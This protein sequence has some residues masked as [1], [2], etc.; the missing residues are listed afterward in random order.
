N[1]ALR[2]KAAM[3]Y[4]F[5][6]RSIAIIG[7]SGVPSKPGGAPLRSLLNNGYTGAVFPVNPNYTT[8]AGLPC[9][10][11]LADIPEEIDL[12]IIAVAA[13]PAMEAL[14]ECAAKKVKAAIVFSSGFAETDSAGATIQEEMVELAKTSGIALC[15]PNCMGIFNAINKMTAGFVISRIPDNL[16]IPEFFGFVSQSGGFSALMHAAASDRSMGFTYFISSGNEADLQFA[17][18][19]A[20]LAM[21]TTTRVIGGYIEGV[22]DGR[23]LM[24]AA[25]IALA[26]QKPVVVIKTGKHPAS[27]KAAASHTGALAGSDRVFQAFVKQKGVI[28]AESVVEFA[29]ILSLLASGNLPAGNR[30]GLIVGSGGNGV[31]LADK[32]S[33]YGLEVTP[34]TDPTVAALEELLPAFGA[35]ANPVDMTSKVLTDANLFRETIRLVLQDPQVDMVIIMHWSSEKGSHSTR[36]IIGLLTEATK[37]VLVL[38]WG[39]DDAAQA[40]LRFFRS[41][42]VPAVREMDNATRS[43]AAIARYS[44]K[45]RTQTGIKV[46]IHERTKATP[47]KGSFLP[48]G[49]QTHKHTSEVLIPH[50]RLKESYATFPSALLDGLAPG[51]ILSES[52]AKNFIRSCGIETTREA[53]AS[54]P[55]EA[56][57]IATGLGYP[58]ALKVCSPDIAHKTEADGVKLN[59][60]T[61]AEIV[62]AYREIMENTRKHQP[63]AHID[64]VLVQ[65]MLTTGIEVIAGISQDPVFGP[66]VLFGL[67]GI[68][69]EAL[70]DVSLRIAPLDYNDAAEMISEIKGAA[71]LAGLRGR[72]AGDRE[73]LIAL[74]VKLSQIAVAFPEISEIDLNPLFVYPP[75]Q[76]VRAVDALVTLK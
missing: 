18:Y 29:T 53:L 30:M 70:D 46:R 66:V 20:Y 48:K 34:L 27:A 42:G 9:Y 56:V 51:T 39:S 76:G 71:V 47:G 63:E 55:E 41:H 13:Q 68:W 62:S 64:C 74:L 11:S 54:N 52:Q 28:R 10:P 4:L 65:E 31:L 50:Q 8:I 72:S 14:R 25:D 3:D 26:A 21:D 61:S 59:L 40:D 23:K 32:C 37:P 35:T 44:A 16:A 57:D 45:L 6:P 75:G 73:A 58:V 60:T 1:P 15:G 12:V 5:Y 17:D 67:G 38:I 43:M 33:E 7:A 22:R 2:E 19:L 69:V 49:Q 24:Q 36:E